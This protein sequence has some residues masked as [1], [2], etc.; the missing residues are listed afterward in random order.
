MRRRA[1]VLGLPGQGLGEGQVF[2][3]LKKPHHAIAGYAFFAHFRVL[4][5]DM[6]WEL[7]G[8]KNGDPDK[9]RFLR[10]I[11]D[12]RDLDLF[13][14]RAPRLPLGCTIL[15]AAVFWPDRIIR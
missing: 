12:Y 13:D 1:S 5:L 14:P 8:W 15:R 11:G 10:R 3:R 2:F 7:F 4:D 9:V 6:A